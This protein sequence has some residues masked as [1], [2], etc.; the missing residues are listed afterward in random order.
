MSQGWC[1]SYFLPSVR[2]KS[3]L[4][5]CVGN[6]CRSPVGERQL[7][8][9][10][11]EKGCAITVS[12]AGIGALVGEGADAT[13]S[14]VAAGHGLSLDGHVARQFTRDLG[15]AQDLILV[16]EHGHRREIARTAPDLSGRVLLFDHWLG[17]VG[18]EDPYRRS[19]EMHEA[20]FAR[21]T[22]A[23]ESW[24]AKLARL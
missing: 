23:A 4:V 1:G 14:A 10:L 6:I 5:V 24:A 20:V 15:A 19:R 3:I 7:V 22:E 21:I 16:M 11:A 12:S 9:R 17:G 13:A 8:A 2:V 18:I